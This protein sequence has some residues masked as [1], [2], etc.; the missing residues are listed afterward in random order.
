M[1]ILGTGLNGLIGSRIIELLGNDFEFESLSRSTGVDI[2]DY[3]SV[4]SAIN[5]SEA[6]IVIHAAAYTDVK[7]AED[8]KDLGENSTAWIINVL[9]T[10]NV[11][12]AVREAG[13]KLIH[14]STDMVVGGDDMPPGGFTEDAKPNPLNWYA[15]TKYEAERIVQNLSSPWIILRTAYPY[16]K[17]FPKPDFVRF[18]KN[19]LAEKKPISVLTDRL[20]TPTFIDDLAPVIKTL[21]EKD[22]TGIYNSVGS[23]IL[24]IYEAVNIIAD[25]FDL[26]KSLISE[27]TRKNFLIDRPAEPFSSALNNAKIKQ[28]GVNMHTFEDGLQIIKNS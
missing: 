24:S 22:A 25:I 9:G 3:E 28:L 15:Q 12:K 7:G 23:Q 17:Q 20:I 26:D 8:Q 14:F 4:Y 27:T 19:W 11:A 18:F 21:I 10:K 1:K 2:S 5:K 6:Q 13:K 16:R